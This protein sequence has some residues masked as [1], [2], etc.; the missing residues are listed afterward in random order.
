MKTQ[1]LV[2]VKL[3]GAAITDKLHAR[4][5]LPANINCLAQQIAQVHNEYP[6]MHIVLGHGSGSFGHFS[7]Q[8]YG[9]RTGVKNSRDWLGFAEVWEDA[10]QLNELVLH[11]FLAAGLPVIAFPPSA[12]LI[13]ENRLPAAYFLEPIHHALQNKLIPV[14]NGDVI[15]DKSLGGTILS[16]E[17]VFSLLADELRPDQIVLASREPGVWQDFPANKK[18]ALTLLPHEFLASTNSIHE[19]SGMDVTGGM[20]KKVSIMMAILQRHPALK[21]SITSGVDSNS[22]FDALT[23]KPSG[24]LLHLE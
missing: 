1:K 19:A 10:R 17:E 12:W 24:T 6:E 13:T 23:G 21:I 3:G 14:V 5:V 2:F 7:G 9:T 8:K 15:F 18:L 4:T 16:T 20:A 22:V 11:A